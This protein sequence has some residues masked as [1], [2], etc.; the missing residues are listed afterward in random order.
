[1]QVRGF[2]L[3]VAAGPDAGR[4][5]AAAKRSLLIGTHPSADLVL[6]DPHVS[7]LHAR[8]DVDETE[9][10]LRDLGSTNGTRA[11]GVRVRE[12]CLDDG[13]SV[14]LGATKLAFRLDAEP[15]E[16]KLAEEELYEGLVGR[17]VAMRELFAVLERAAPSEA[18]IL[19]EGETGTGKE[20]VARG[21][22]ARSARS[23][24]PVVVLD[25]GAVPAGLIESE[26]FGHERGAFTGAVAAHKGVFERA[27]GGT[28]FLDELGELPLELQPKLLRALESGEI[29]RVGGE[30]MLKVDVRVVAATHRDLP[31]LIAEGKF[32]A[33]LFYRLAVIRVRIPP[34]RERRDDIPLLSAHFARE[35]LGDRA[36]P[37]IALEA[38]FERLRSYPWPGNVRELRNIV[39]RALILADP[40]LV[41]ASALDAAQEIS[42]SVDQTLRKRIP[43]RAARNEREREY[44]HD[45]VRATDGNLEEA[46]AIAEIHVKSLERLLRK[47]KLRVA[48]SRGD[49]T[50]G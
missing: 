21:L 14:E 27:H 41:A 10:V 40:K 39:E 19:L 38:V 49:G 11:G 31:R 12:V 43:L 22:H 4:R 36:L 15:F 50:S 9:F 6:T 26:L 29:T 47:H 1:M 30:K 3:E 33:D 5:V 2:G 32:R 7:R 17:S 37:A 16:I 24:A 13:T 34:L 44:L 23:R 45:L 28:L 8:I 46:A 42:R 35:L 20:L 25:C 18:S 48:E